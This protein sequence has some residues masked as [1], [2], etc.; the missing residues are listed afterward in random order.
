MLL[1]RIGLVDIA[2]N[3]K[4]CTC[5][6]HLNNMQS[7]TRPIDKGVCLMA[8]S[9]FF[10]S[11]ANPQLPVDL[12][13]QMRVAVVEVEIQAAGTWARM[14]A[15]STENTF[16]RPHAGSPTRAAW[17]CRRKQRQHLQPRTLTSPSYILINPTLTLTL[18]LQGENQ[19]TAS[20][21]RPQCPIEL[22]QLRHLPLSLTPT[23]LQQT[24][25]LCQQDALGPSQTHK[26]AQSLLRPR[27]RLPPP[28][29]WEGRCCPRRQWGTIRKRPSR[30]RA[31]RATRRVRGDRRGTASQLCRSRGRKRCPRRGSWGSACVWVR[32]KARGRVWCRIKASLKRLSPCVASAQSSTPACSSPRFTATTVTPRCREKLQKSHRDVKDSVSVKCHWFD[33]NIFTITKRA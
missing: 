27:T 10:C 12:K 30:G 7:A 26:P 11:R 29:S 1:L 4:H 33:W 25:L 22:H 15:R 21:T 20:P 28:A 32:L 5:Q 24:I 3:A 8:L 2:T 9:C 16:P 23:V 18:Y 14:T 17:R 19:E 31:A 13:L 6:A